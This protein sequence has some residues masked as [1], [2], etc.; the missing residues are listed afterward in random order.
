MCGVPRMIALIMRGFIVKTHRIVIIGLLIFALLIG[1]TAC[2]TKAPPLDLESSSIESTEEASSEETEE[3]EFEIT[4]EVSE[5]PETQSALNGNSAHKASTAANT[6]SNKPTSTSKNYPKGNYKE[7][8]IN[9]SYVTQAEMDACAEVVLKFLSNHVKSNMSDYEKIKAAN[10][11]LCDN[12]SYLQD[13]PKKT[14]NIYGAF[15]LGKAD[16]WGYSSAFQYLCTAM[17]IECYFVIPKNT[18]NDWHRWNIVK[19]E[20]SYYHVDVQVNDLDSEHDVKF[21]ISDKTIGANADTM[22]NYPAC[23]NDYITNQE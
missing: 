16:C 15:V 6:S 11:Y 3:S 14:S 23:P 18:G 17:E 22:K 20:E 7:G 9:G 21:L 13:I 4:P 5:I 8:M 1:A 12:I 19:L 10:D 2:R